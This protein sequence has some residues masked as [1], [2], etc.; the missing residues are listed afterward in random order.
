MS[1]R[2]SKEDFLM[3]L[4]GDFA[5]AENMCG[6]EHPAKVDFLRLLVKQ[7]KEYLLKRLR[8]LLKEQTYVSL[9]DAVDEQGFVWGREDW[10]FIDDQVREWDK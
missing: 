2:V 10:E 7:R 9:P 3:E 8:V 1:E 4:E 6:S 5:D